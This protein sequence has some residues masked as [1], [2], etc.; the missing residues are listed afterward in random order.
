[1][2]RRL[3][4]L[5]CLSA[6]Y[7]ASS[8]SQ[9]APLFETRAVWFATVLGDGGWPASTLDTPAKQA[10]DLRD[11]IRTAHALGMNTFIFQAVARGDAMYPSARLPWS[12]R[13]RGP[14]VDPGY[15][16]LA[17]AIDE[18]HALGMELHV[19]FNVFR[20]GDTTTESLFAGVD[21][22]PHVIHAHPEW[23]Q[24]VDGS[25]WIDPSSDEARAWLVDNVMEIV[26]GYDLDAIHFDFI[27]YPAG[28]LTEDGA[29]F[30]FNPRGFDLIDDWR[31]DNVTRFVRDVYARVLAVKPWVKIGSA[32]LGNYEPFPGAWPALWAFT[33]VFQESR[34]WLQEGLHDYLAPQLYFDIGRTPEPGNDVDSPDFDYL[35]RD[36][37]SGAGGLP[38]F[39]GLG[40]FKSIVR[41]EILAQIDTTRVAGAQG[42][43]FFRYDHLLAIAD[44]LAVAYPHPALPA[45]MTHRFEATVPTAP[46]LRD[47]LVTTSFRLAWTA[48]AGSA[49]DPVRAYAVFMRS[50]SPPEAVPAD[51]VAVVPATATTWEGIRYDVPPDPPDYFRV[52]ALSRLGMLS[53]LSPAVST[54]DLIVT[55]TEDA[56][57]P[58]PV[59]LTAL[60]PN[61]ASST[62]RLVFSLGDTRPVTVMLTDLLG[63]RARTYEAGLRGPGVHTLV[64]DVSG[65]ASGVYLGRFEAGDRHVVR[66][67]VILH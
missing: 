27:R 59:R 54:D 14:G 8:H 33:D 39:A 4:L 38:I 41:E 15:D 52:A 12:A 45:P 66:R 46:A 6:L 20:V 49:T 48:S 61:P 34:R 1:M 24:F 29:A 18:A 30:Q 7:A 26:E 32:P 67:V 42:Q 19:W 65:L 44:D 47:D 62:L 22:P 28:G 16:P 50:G 25:P 17:V 5:L 57:T 23:V 11:R 58:D 10:D 53:T 63:R 9:P 51:L 37:V 36:W 31:R 40:P 55:G 2:P 43:A 21:D 64:L 60:Y 35:V 3:F 56:G 13:L